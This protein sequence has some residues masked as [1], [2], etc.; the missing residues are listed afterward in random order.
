[1][2]PEILTLTPTY[3]NVNIQPDIPTINLSTKPPNRTGIP[4]AKSSEKPDLK[5]GKH[6]PSATQ[7]DIPTISP[8]HHTQPAI[9]TLATNN[10]VSWIQ[11]DIPT[12]SFTTPNIT[13]PK[14]PATQPDI[15][16]IS[17]YKP[18]YAKSPSTQ[19]DI[20][21]ISPNQ[22]QPNIPTISLKSS[23]TQPDIPTISPYKPMYAKSPSTQPDI[24]T[25]SQYQINNSNKANWTQSQTPEIPTLTPAINNSVR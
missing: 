12:I 11:P 2:Q 23:A 13:Y 4:P 6:Q 5:A 1:M 21:T 10:N 16:T 19:P 22:T 17:P 14:A 15:P 18:M 25:I 24:P 9:P 7:P 8:S 3:I 20:P